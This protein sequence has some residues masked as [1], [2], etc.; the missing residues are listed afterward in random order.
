MFSIT[1]DGMIRSQMICCRV[2]AD[3]NVHT[4]PSKSRLIPKIIKL[5]IKSAHVP[6][7][8]DTSIPPMSFLLNVAA[9]IAVASSSSFHKIKEICW[10]LSCD[11]FKWTY[12]GSLL[13]C[14]SHPLFGTFLWPLCCR[15]KWCHPLFIPQTKL[16]LVNCCISWQ[17]QEEAR[18]LLHGVSRKQV[19]LMISSIHHLLLLSLCSS[20]S[21]TLGWDPQVGG[22]RFN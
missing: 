2:E 3:T 20:H 11:L 14:W 5:S 8:S 18:G 16:W 19:T 4:H 1:A 21:Q 22:R 13:P 10:F 12:S 15:Y 6:N 17:K 9:T 7:I